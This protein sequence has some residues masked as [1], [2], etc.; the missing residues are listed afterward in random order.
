[1][2]VAA[3]VLCC[4]AMVEQANR[5]ACA[6]ELYAGR[7]QAMSPQLVPQY[8]QEPSLQGARRS[9]AGQLTLLTG[10]QEEPGKEDIEERTVWAAL[11]LRV[12]PGVLSACAAPV[13]PASVSS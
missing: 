7:V 4:W 3:G 10:R 5:Q 6:G 12:P 9:A 13:G 8:L 1:M 11:V 2:V